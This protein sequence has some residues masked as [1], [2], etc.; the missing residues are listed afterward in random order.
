V[1]GE[2]FNEPVWD[3]SARDYAELGAVL[4][5]IGAP[6]DAIV[7]VNNPPGFALAT[8][9]AAI[10]IPNGDV[11]T[12]L[13]AAERYGATYLLLEENHPQG[14]SG[15][16]ATPQSADGLQYL[17]TINGTHIFLIGER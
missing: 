7:M 4:N 8:Q 13:A 11:A 15:L 17:Q 1:L 2:N 16:Y 3:E 6:A 5:Q 9:H 12:S 10:V 14:L